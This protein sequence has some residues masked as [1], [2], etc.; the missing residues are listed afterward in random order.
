MEEGYKDELKT[1]SQLLA[2]LFAGQKTSRRPMY[3]S[4]RRTNS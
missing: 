3:I 1:A 4:S 2:D